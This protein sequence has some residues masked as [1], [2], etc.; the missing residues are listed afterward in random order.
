VAAAPEGNPPPAPGAADPEVPVEA[1]AA[2]GAPR[3]GEPASARTGTLHVNALPWGNVAV[4][5]RAVGETPVTVALPPGPHRIRITHPSYGAR[6]TG[7]TI[8]AGRET[9]WTPNLMRR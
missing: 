9:T 3:D 4:D 1:P 5:G 8:A 2:A 6:E 7:V